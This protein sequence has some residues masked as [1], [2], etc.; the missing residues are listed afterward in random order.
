MDILF[1]VYDQ[2]VIIQS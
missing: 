2:N 1:S